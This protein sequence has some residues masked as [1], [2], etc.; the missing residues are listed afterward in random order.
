MGLKAGQWAQVCLDQ[1]MAATAALT[2]ALS[3]A[4][5]AIPLPP[6][7][8][9]RAELKVEIVSTRKYNLI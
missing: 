2:A 5:G 9:T 7:W 8:P 6:V 4:P 1:C 3:L